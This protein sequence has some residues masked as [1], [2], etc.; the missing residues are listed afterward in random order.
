MTLRAP[1]RICILFL[2]AA[3][4]LSAGGFE[5][6]GPG[7]SSAEPPAEHTLKPVADAS[8]DIGAPTGQAKSTSDSPPPTRPFSSIAT[9]VRDYPRVA[10]SGRCGPRYKN[11]TR[12]SCIADKPC[13]GYGIRNDENE[14]LCMC[15]L[16]HG[17][18]DSK[19]RCDDRAHACLADTIQKSREE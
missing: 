5:P 15:Y 1:I 11:G 7:G 9:P 3:I 17:G 8:A 16:T 13:R 19:S 10:S 12:G 4:S 2:S 18:C 6:H 14:V